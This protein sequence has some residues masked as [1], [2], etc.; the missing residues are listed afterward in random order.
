M[1]QAVS[2]KEGFR[3]ITGAG[4]LNYVNLVLPTV[5]ALQQRT[6]ELAIPRAVPQS[7]VNSGGLCSF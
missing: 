3:W 4:M 2:S 1:T 5:T 7:A 6:P